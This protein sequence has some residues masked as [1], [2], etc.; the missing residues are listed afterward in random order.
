MAGNVVAHHGEWIIVHE[1]KDFIVVNTKKKFSEVNHTHLNSY[2]RAVNL[3]EFART[4]TIPR[5]PTNFIL[6]S[7]QR[8]SR[9]KQYIRELELRKR[10]LIEEKYNR[11]EV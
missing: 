1:G 9:D 4:K 8:V 5:H 6:T 10:E 2:K 3:I 7:L 11:G